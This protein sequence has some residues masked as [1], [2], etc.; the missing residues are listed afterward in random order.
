MQFSFWLVLQQHCNTSCGQVATWACPLRTILATFLGLQRLHK[1][2][3]GLLVREP[4]SENCSDLIIAAPP[5]WESYHCTRYKLYLS[6]VKA[7]ITHAI[8]RP[9]SF[10]LM[11]RYC[12]NLKAK[13]YE[14]TTLNRIVADKSHRVP[15]IIIFFS[16]ILTI[17]SRDMLKMME[18]KR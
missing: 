1:V 15:F 5:F 10:V 13:R 16:I 14:S 3:L 8:Y 17:L 6:L 11:L 18:K 9:D 2:E 4:N 12:E 7:T